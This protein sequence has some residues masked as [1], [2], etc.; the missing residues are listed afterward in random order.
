M[1]IIKFII[2]WERLVKWC[3]CRWRGCI[4]K[5]LWAQKPISVVFLLDY[6]LCFVKGGFERAQC[7]PLLAFKKIKKFKMWNSCSDTQNKYFKKIQGICQ[8]YK[9]IYSK[10]TFLKWVV[11]DIPK[12]C[13]CTRS[14]IRSFGG[15][16][17][18]ERQWAIKVMCIN[19]TSYF[20]CEL[21]SS[22]P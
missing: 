3:F 4:P 22:I 21:K 9:L 12:F 2:H 14:V 19:H 16:L 6:L 20:N 18:L 1:M 13:N 11:S 8:R 5:T 10:E 17:L 15:I 7:I